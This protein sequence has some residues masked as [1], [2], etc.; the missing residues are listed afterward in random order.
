MEKLVK[1]VRA[2]ERRRNGHPG[3][4]GESSPAKFEGIEVDV[5]YAIYVEQIRVLT[6]DFERERADRVTLK[7]E[8]DSLRGVVDKLKELCTQWECRYWAMA[9]NRRK[10]ERL[11]GYECDCLGEDGEE[12][13][14]ET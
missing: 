13:A 14:V 3:K 10:N 6:E 2:L 1:R 9:N 12:D 7:E 8:V 5:K 11:P 4:D